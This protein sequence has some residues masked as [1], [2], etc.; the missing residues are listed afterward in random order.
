MLDARGFPAKWV[1]FFEAVI[2]AGNT[3]CN[4][5]LSKEVLQV[6]RYVVS[7]LAAAR[8]TA[9]PLPLPVNDYP[10]LVRAATSAFKEKCTKPENAWRILELLRIT[11]HSPTLQ[12]FDAVWEVAI[13]QMTNSG[14]KLAVPYLQNNRSLPELASNM[15]SACSMSHSPLGSSLAFGLLPIGMGLWAHSQALAQAHKLWSHVM[16]F[17]KWLCAPLA[18]I[19]S[20]SL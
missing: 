8:R 2:R 7:G 1:M 4:I 13:R 15:C 14:E 5:D 20:M 19:P 11:R 18:A 9:F 6:H 16:Q 12:L 17:G 10:H 3:H